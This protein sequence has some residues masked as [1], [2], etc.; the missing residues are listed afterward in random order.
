MPENENGS[1]TETDNPTTEPKPEEKPEPQ[2]DG[3]DWKAESR[4]WEKRAKDNSDAAKRLK[5]LEDKDK[6]ESEKL[7]ER[8]TSAEKRAE[9]AE[10]RALK[11]EVAHEKGLTAKQAKRLQGSTRE[12]LEADADDLLESFPAGKDGKDDEPEE[13][14]PG[15]GR[16]KEKLRPGASPDTEPARTP[17]EIADAVIKRTRG[18]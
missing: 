4:K 10:A 14:K 12:E 16:P 1:T 6:S 3:T 5:E 15:H 2:G 13:D 11:A 9:E 8:A 17:R 18:L 7:S